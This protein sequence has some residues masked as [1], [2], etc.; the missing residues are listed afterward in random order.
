MGVGHRITFILVLHRIC[1]QG[2]FRVTARVMA[3]VCIVEGFG[4]VLNGC[5]GFSLEI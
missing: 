2:V 5:I 3:V 4:D 1:E